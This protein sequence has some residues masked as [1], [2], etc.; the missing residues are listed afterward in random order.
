VLAA[1]R[2]DGS[3]PVNLGTGHEITIR[4]LVA[5]IAALTRFTGQIRWNPSKPE[6]QPRR[7]LDTGRALALFGFEAKTQLAVGLME[8]VR[9]KPESGSDQLF[10]HDVA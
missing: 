1:E 9:S 10:P 6:G 3:D 7:A 8:T 5:I 2:Y 4:E